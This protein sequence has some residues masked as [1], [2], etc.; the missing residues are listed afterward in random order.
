E[1]ANDK[2]RE[3]YALRYWITE[4]TRGSASLLDLDRFE[5]PWSY[6]LEVGQ[7]SAAETKPVTVDLVETFNYLLG[8]RVQKVDRIEPRNRDGEPLRPVT[9]VQGTLPPAPGRESGERAL[10]IW[11]DTTSVSADDLDYFL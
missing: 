9:M 2:F 5:D 7:G 11:R 8:L 3:Q 6:T 1:R 10:V 4:E